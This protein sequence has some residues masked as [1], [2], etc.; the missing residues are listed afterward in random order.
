LKERIN[1]TKINK[2][3]FKLVS[4]SVFLFVFLE[5]SE[6]FSFALE[7]VANTSAQRSTYNPKVGFFV[8]LLTFFLNYIYDM[9]KSTDMQMDNQEDGIQPH[10][11]RYPVHSEPIEEELG[12]L[13]TENVSLDED[14]ESLNMN[15]SIDQTNIEDE[16]KSYDSDFDMESE[17]YDEDL[18]GFEENS[19]KDTQAFDKEREDLKELEESAFNRESQ[20]ETAWK[21]QEEFLEKLKYSQK[22]LDFNNSNSNSEVD[23]YQPDKDPSELDLWEEDDFDVFDD[24]E[25]FENN[26]IEEVGNI[27]E[28]QD[29]FSEEDL[30]S[31]YKE[32]K[33]GHLFSDDEDEKK[34]AIKSHQEDFNDTN[35]LEEDVE[36]E[37]REIEDLDEDIYNDELYKTIVKEFNQNYIEDQDLDDTIAHEEQDI[38]EEISNKKP[39]N[40][41]EVFKASDSSANP[42]VLEG[43]NAFGEGKV[44]ENPKTGKFGKVLESDNGELIFENIVANKGIYRLVFSCRA[45]IV[46]TIQLIINDGK[47]FEV[48]I[49]GDGDMEDTIELIMEIQLV[50]GLNKIK[51]INPSYQNI[52]LEKIELHPVGIEGKAKHGVA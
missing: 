4:F 16:N 27:S 47:I 50:N 40:R 3:I 10:L 28:S 41:L 15:F 35:S 23:E 38:D 5:A 48:D 21:D 52:L 25:K 2:F 24:F 46:S 32:L 22:V 19:V 11:E 17:L 44:I 18:F 29:S 43:K 33:D 39:I 8:A 1:L 14:L 13:E 30:K 9:V 51:F 31:L 34:M 20:G 49:L 42:I 26:G 12:Y 6:T 36:E 7:L 37:E 45:L